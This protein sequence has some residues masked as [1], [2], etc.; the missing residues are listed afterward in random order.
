[1]EDSKQRIYVKDKEYYFHKCVFNSNSSQS[2]KNQNEF[3]IQFESTFKEGN[4]I[5]KSNFEKNCI[6]YLIKK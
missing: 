5:E 1:M 4:L 2:Q 3:V 6:N